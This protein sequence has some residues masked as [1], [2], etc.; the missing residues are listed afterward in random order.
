M[1]G[2]LQS[3]F[4]VFIFESAS[5]EAQIGLTLAVALWRPPASASRV[6]G[7]QTSTIMPGPEFS[8]LKGDVRIG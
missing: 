7:L 4:Y 3:P 5:P 2:T 6:L 8:S 1:H